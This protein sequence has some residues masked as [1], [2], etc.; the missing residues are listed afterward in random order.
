MLFRSPFQQTE[1]SHL[2]KFSL[3]KTTQPSHLLVKG[4]LGT[5]RSQCVSISSSRLL[6]LCA[7]PGTVHLRMVD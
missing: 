4:S 2:P 5:S 1:I 7:Y 6:A 3:L